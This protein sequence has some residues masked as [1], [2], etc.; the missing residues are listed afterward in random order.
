MIE[1]V[2]SHIGGV[3]LYGVISICIF[4][5]VFTGALLWASG[6][7]RPHLQSMSELPLNDGSAPAHETENPHDCHE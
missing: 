3:G 7:T 4:F 6:L 1:N 2:L 5:A